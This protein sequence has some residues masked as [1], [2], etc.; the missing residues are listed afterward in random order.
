M[1]HP[2]RGSLSSMDERVHSWVHLT[3]LSHRRFLNQLKLFPWMRLS[4]IDRFKLPY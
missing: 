4:I 3:R 1:L 2:I